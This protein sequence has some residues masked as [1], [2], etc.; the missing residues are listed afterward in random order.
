MRC[1][2]GTHTHTVRHNRDTMKAGQIYMYIFVLRALSLCVLSFPTC[3]SRFTHIHTHTHCLCLYRCTQRLPPI[4]RMRGEP[5]ARP[6]FL[7]LS[8]HRHT[9]THTYTHI[10]TQRT[11][12]NNPI[13]T[14]ENPERDFIHQQRLVRLMYHVQQF[15]PQRVYP[16]LSHL[17]NGNPTH[18]YTQTDT[19]LP[20]VSSLSLSLSL[21]L[22][23][24]FE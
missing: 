5:L 20:L 16:F 7:S 22:L 9:H 10:H 14:R 15:L 13:Q 2:R 24:D 17:S 23:L 11:Q 3:M 6:L 1:Q 18:V 19:L 8:S 21:S 4:A 12:R